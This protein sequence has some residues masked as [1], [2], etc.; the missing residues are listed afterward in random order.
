MEELDAKRCVIQKLFVSFSLQKAKKSR[1]TNPTANRRLACKME[2]RCDWSIT[3][4]SEYMIG[5]RVWND[6]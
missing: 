1:L 4:G 2:R 6:D 5:E 3:R